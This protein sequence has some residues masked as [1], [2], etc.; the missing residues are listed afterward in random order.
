MSRPSPVDCIPKQARQALQRPNSVI[1]NPSLWPTPGPWPAFDVPRGRNPVTVR[2][3]DS[4]RIVEP[5]T[6]RLQGCLETVIRVLTCAN[7]DRDCVL[8]AGV[9]PGS[10]SFAPRLMPRRVYASRPV[11]RDHIPRR[12]GAGASGRCGTAEHCGA[13]SAIGGRGC[14]TAGRTASLARTL[15]SWRPTDCLLG[16][17]QRDADIGEDLPVQCPHARGPRDHVLRGAGARDRS[18][19]PHPHAWPRR[20]PTES[21]RTAARSGP[22]PVS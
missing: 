11:S 10:R 21:A 12:A 16:P 20:P 8:G 15:G 14:G 9:A 3:D 7:S 1:L 22:G 6:S 17:A 5:T 2:A 19:R 18:I 13:G 4:E